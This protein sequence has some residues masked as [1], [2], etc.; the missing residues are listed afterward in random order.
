MLP[1]A[2]AVFFTRFVITKMKIPLMTSLAVMVMVSSAEYIEQ[3]DGMD[4]VGELEATS[5][6]PYEA[7]AYL[8]SVPPPDGHAE[9]YNSADDIATCLV[10]VPMFSK[11]TAKRACKAEDGDLESEL[12]CF[13]D[14]SKSFS[15]GASA[16]ICHYQ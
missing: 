10:S 5:S 15:D 13:L 2:I 4:C 9:G 7:V 11:S 16:R 12:D 8:C 14:V 1:D 6:I 3:S